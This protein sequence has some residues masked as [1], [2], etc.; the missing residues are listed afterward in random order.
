MT[1]PFESRRCAYLDSGPRGVNILNR[2]SSS[3]VTGPHM[4]NSFMWL[5]HARLFGQFHFLLPEQIAILLGRSESIDNAAFPGCIQPL[6][7]E[8]RCSIFFGA[9]CHWFIIIVLSTGMGYLFWHPLQKYELFSVGCQLRPQRLSQSASFWWE[10]AENVV[11]IQDVFSLECR[12]GMAECCRVS[13]TFYRLFISKSTK[14]PLILFMPAFFLDI[15]SLSFA[16]SSLW[17][18]LLAPQLFDLW[19][20]A[21]TL[22]N[23]TH[24][25]HAKGLN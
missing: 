15:C 11:I 19:P 14:R 4:L 5:I 10:M 7:E 18:S 21:E 24:Q 16:L 2:I 6:I 17:V 20:T 22:Q 25:M 1:F 13:G 9:L 3:V 12:R 23:V 8:K